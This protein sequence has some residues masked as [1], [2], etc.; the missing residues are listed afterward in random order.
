MLR[1]VAKH[2]T[3]EE[4]HICE[5]DEVAVFLFTSK[6]LFLYLQPPFPYS[7]H[8]HTHKHT[9]RVIEV[10]KRYFP[11]TA[12]GFSSPK[13]K[14]HI[15]DG[16]EFMQQC[17]GQFDVIISDVSDPAGEDN[18]LVPRPSL[19]LDCVH[20]NLPLGSTVNANQLSEVKCFPG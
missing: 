5:I 2:K 12:V 16:A 17:V 18:S 6:F 20:Y 4:I 19:F 15:Q 9:Q 11:Q 13:V 10:S 3:V 14:V 7:P 8:T 1:E